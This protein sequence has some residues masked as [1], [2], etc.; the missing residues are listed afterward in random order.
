MIC[1][2]CLITT[3]A[4]ADGIK[5]YYWGAIDC[6]PCKIWEQSFG[7]KLEQEFKAKNYRFQKVVKKSIRKNWNEVLFMETNLGETIQE[8]IKS[9]TA[10]I[11][12][13]HF[14]YF[15]G[16]ERLFDISGVNTWE[17]VHSKYM[18]A[19]ESLN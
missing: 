7:T 15:L 19:L 3:N 1:V 2:T 14:T 12:T 4:S 8:I 18:I 9:G 11:A 13:P 17:E 10:P 16:D 5:M 6:V